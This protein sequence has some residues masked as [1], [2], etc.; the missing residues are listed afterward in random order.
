MAYVACVVQNILRVCSESNSL[1]ILNPVCAF[2]SARVGQFS[3]SEGFVLGE[4]QGCASWVKVT[5][6]NYS[7][8]CP[9]VHRHNR[10]SKKMVG[11]IAGEVED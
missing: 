9:G 10:R 3:G 4:M 11:D 2:G 7:V 1:V 5:L 6:L 8:G